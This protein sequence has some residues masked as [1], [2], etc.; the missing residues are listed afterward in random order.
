METAVVAAGITYHQPCAGTGTSL[1]AE[2]LALFQALEVAAD[3]GVK[4]LVLIGDAA[5]VIAKAAG[6]A[7]P[8]AKRERDYAARFEM[9]A[10]GFDRVRLRHVKRTQNLAGIA[11]ARFRRS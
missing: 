3:L 1:E 4:D 6:R 11:L 5:D 8:R 7:P 9:A 2:W 10:R